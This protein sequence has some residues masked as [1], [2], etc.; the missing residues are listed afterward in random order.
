VQN[1]VDQFEER[2]G[3]GLIPSAIAA[4]P[5]APRP[6]AGAVATEPWALK[7]C[8]ITPHRRLEPGWVVVEG[9]RIAQVTGAEPEGIRWL[10]TDGVILPGLIDLH[11][12]PEYNVFAPWEPPSL[13]PNRYAWRASLEY[14]AVVKQPWLWFGRSP[15]LLHQLSRYA[16]IR[17]AVGGSTAIQGASQSYP[18]PDHAL[19]RHVDL[20]PFGRNEYASMVDPLTDADWAKQLRDEIRD[21]ITAGRIK[22]FYAHLAE[23]T[24]DGSRAELEALDG[25]GLLGSATVLIHGTALTDQQ[26]GRVREADAKLVWSPQSNLRLYGGTTRAAEARRLQTPVGLGAD[27]LPS[28]SVS[29]LAEM[30]VAR[31]V[32]AE[33]GDPIEARELVEMVT[34]GAASIA[35]LEAFIGEL[36]PGRR[37]DMLVL[38]RR[39]TDPYEAVCEADRS[40]VALVAIDGNLIYGRDD[41]FTSLLPDHQAEEILAWGRRMRLDTSAHTV[42]GD[43]PSHLSD[44]RR[45]LLGRYP[46][47]GPIFA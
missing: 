43:P 10:D 9:S 2:Y 1:A 47:I 4:A 23:G 19:V 27:W 8:V 38:E 40:S 7:G 29:L 45:A 16:E 37:A 31:R 13:Y 30:K 20:A 15:S 41:W 46:Q 33:Q 17:A 11:G 32:L 18:L 22:R 26:L 21:G 34:S 28:G 14:D 36:R 24:D 39:N 3:G 6:Q 5:V 25:Y 35:G 12:H 42:A 44:V